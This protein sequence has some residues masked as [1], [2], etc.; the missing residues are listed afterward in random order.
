MSDDKKDI[1]SMHIRTSSPKDFYPMYIKPCSPED[2][3]GF[4]AEVIDLP[5]CIADGETI[6]EAIIASRDAVKSWLKTAA[7]HGDIY[8]F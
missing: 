6:E 1:Y 5:G 8:H 3:G 4:I 2:G 7:E